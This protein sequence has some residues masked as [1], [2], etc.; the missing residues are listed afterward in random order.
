MPYL[1]DNIIKSLLNIKERV[2]V[3]LSTHIL[4]EEQ[5]LKKKITVTIL[6]NK[7]I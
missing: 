3:K 4:N 2:L 7:Q 6:E 1:E 5:I